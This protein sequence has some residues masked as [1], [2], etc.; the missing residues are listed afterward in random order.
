MSKST[1]TSTVIT[2]NAEARAA[3]GKVVQVSGTIHR[4]KLGD[5]V[6]SG[7]LSVRCPDFRFPEALVNKVG[8]AEGTLEIVTDEAVTVSPAGE[9]GQGFDVESSTFVLRGCTARP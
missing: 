1:S 6:N 9:H 4:E 8:T 5:T 7:E 3:V 2:T